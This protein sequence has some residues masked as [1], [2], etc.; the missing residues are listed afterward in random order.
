[1]ADQINWEELTDDDL[2]A[3]IWLTKRIVQ[4][5]NQLLDLNNIAYEQQKAVQQEIETLIQQRE[6]L[7]IR[8]K[9]QSR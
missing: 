3:L 2:D 8:Y 1:M 5:S 7:L 4:L 9:K 6:A